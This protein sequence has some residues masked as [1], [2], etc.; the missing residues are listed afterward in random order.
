MPFADLQRA[1]PLYGAS[2]GV[3]RRRR[4]A[5]HFFGQSRLPKKSPRFSCPR[6]PLSV[7]LTLALSCGCGL[8]RTARSARLSRL[9]SFGGY[10]T[11]A[12]CPP[13]RARRPAVTLV[14][15]R[16]AAMPRRLT[17]ASPSRGGWRPLRARRVAPRLPSLTL[18]AF[19]P[20][21]PQ[22]FASRPHGAQL[23]SSIETIKDRPWLPP[24][25]FFFVWFAGVLSN[26][27]LVDYPTVHRA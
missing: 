20:A 7:G 24:R 2:H 15:A 8:T 23:S 26:L 25:S 6:N 22:P 5:R 27:I 12:V 3:L 19:R 14:V 9:T 21:H 16:C 10:P 17:T 18:G 11:A 1:S 4:K 13:S